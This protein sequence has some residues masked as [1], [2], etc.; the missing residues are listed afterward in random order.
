[1]TDAVIVDVDGTL[2]DVTTAIPHLYDDQGRK[3]FDA[4]H[5]ASAVCPPNWQA[6]SYVVRAHAA[7]IVVA[8]V[9]ARMYRWQEL[10]E[11]WL[12]EHMPVPYVGPFMR[13]D[14]D[15]RTDVEVKR[16]IYRVL[17]QTH[18]YR[19]IG[20]IDDNP[21]IIDLWSSLGIPT[22]TVPREWTDPDAPR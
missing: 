20:A 21:P 3:T 11:A 1:M 2:V 16:D 10:T 8:V 19:I 5:Q 7:G 18:G 15:Y 13:G 4:F 17:T 9:T 14:T 6:I 12:A 22:E